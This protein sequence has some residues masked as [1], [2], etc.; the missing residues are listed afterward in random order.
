[1]ISRTAMGRPAQY[2]T[3]MVDDL[4]ALDLAWLRR[5]GAQEPGCRGSV[6]W[7]DGSGDRRS[8][9]YLLC[10]AGLYLTR[11]DSPPAASEFIPIV[12]LPAPFG[13][14]RHWFK[15][16]RCS[17]RCR[18][19]YRAPSFRCRTCAGAQY[20]SKYESPAVNL[21]NARWRLRDKM[22]PSL[23]PTSHSGLDEKFPAKP[24][25]MHWSTYN[26]L[27]ERYEAYDNQWSLEAMRRF[28]KLL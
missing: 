28:S 16:P 12:T 2:L 7:T 13:G 23:K 17:R 25:G 3:T 8:V 9:R 15:C 10:Q 21:S 27:A 26:C 11:P 6:S 18:I 14:E 24:K 1:M 20:R 5:Q 4:D 19:I 22:I